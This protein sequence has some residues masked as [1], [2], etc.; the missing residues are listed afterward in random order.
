MSIPTSTAA[1]AADGQRSPQ[2]PTARHAAP[3]AQVAP[4]GESAAA[5]SGAGATREEIVQAVEEVNEALTLRSVGV[6]FEVDSETE[7]LVVKVVDRESGELIRQ[8][9]SEE[10]LRIAKVLGRVPGLLV[11]ESA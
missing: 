3:A 5:S 7:R 1:V 6:R 11:S 2:L 10:V 4:A 8:M 9:P